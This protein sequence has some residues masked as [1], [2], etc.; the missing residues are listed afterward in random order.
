MTY[1]LW[2]HGELLGESALD[3]VRVD[4]NVRMGDLHVTARG[5]LFIERLTQSHEDAYHAACRL[6]NEPVNESDLK[7]LQA[8]LGAERDQH[9]RLAF[10]LRGPDGSVLDT[11]RIDVTDT[12][13]LRSIGNDSCDEDGFEAERSVAECDDLYAFEDCLA[14]FSD[15]SRPWLP[16]APEHEPVRFQIMARLKSPWSIP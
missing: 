15:E 2:S 4:P 16:E 6:R 10:E 8:D 13:Y 5:L 7:A 3:Y 11:E 1:T 9:E 14:E 12:D